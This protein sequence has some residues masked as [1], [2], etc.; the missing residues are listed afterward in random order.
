MELVSSGGLDSIKGENCPIE[1]WDGRH[2]LPLEA[3]VLA[4]ASAVVPQ[5]DT[6]DSL[7]STMEGFR[8]LNL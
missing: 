1:T 5:R 7:I 4:P 6:K 8:K 3:N 2:Y